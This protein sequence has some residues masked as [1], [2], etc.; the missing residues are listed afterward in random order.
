MVFLVA[1]NC[2]E[3]KSRKACHYHQGIFL[4]GNFYLGPWKGFHCMISCSCHLG[5]LSFVSQ[6]W[7]ARSGL[8][9]LAGLTDMVTGG[10][11]AAVTQWEPG[12]R[13]KGTRPFPQVPLGAL[14]PNLDSK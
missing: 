4:N 12:G 9:D 11:Q 3:I 14:C 1:Q 8:T 5:T 6:G 10:G 7:E 13:G 2:N